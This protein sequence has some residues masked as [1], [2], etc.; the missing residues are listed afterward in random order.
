MFYY[1]SFYFLIVFERKCMVLLVFIVK[2]LKLST[3]KNC[4]LNN[5]SNDLEI[6]LT[7]NW[8]SFLYLKLGITKSKNV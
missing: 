6:S 8:V 1:Y 3:L 7:H 4:V 2:C 5:A